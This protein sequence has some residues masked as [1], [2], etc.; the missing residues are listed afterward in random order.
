[1]ILYCERLTWMIPNPFPVASE[2]SLILLDPRNQFCVVMRQSDLIRMPQVIAVDAAPQYENTL[3]SA[4]IPVEQNTWHLFRHLVELHEALKR[5]GAPPLRTVHCEKLW[6]LV[7][8][9][10]Q[11]HELPSHKTQLLFSRDF[12]L[13]DRKRLREYSQQ[14]LKQR[15]TSYRTQKHS[16]YLRRRVYNHEKGGESATL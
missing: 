14:T 5:A 3:P 13:N 15:Q 11:E 6:I 8:A 7:V 10:F 16:P 1:M 9:R 2:P 4:L 12:R